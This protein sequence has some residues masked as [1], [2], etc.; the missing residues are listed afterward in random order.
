MPRPWTIPP[1]LALLLCLAL[2]PAAAAGSITLRISARASLQNQRLAVLV[3][4]SNTG[5][6]AAHRLSYTVLLGRRS[7]RASGAARLA[8]GASDQRELTLPFQAPQPGGYGFGVRVD[9]HDQRGYPL[10]AV[11][12]GLFAKQRLA[13][14]RLALSGRAGHPWPGAPPAFVLRNPLDRPLT[15][16]LEV[17]APAEF[18]LERSQWTVQLAPGQ[19]AVVP[20]ELSNRGALTGSTY[21]LAGLASY[22]SGG[23][24]H[25]AAAQVLV[26]VGALSDPLNAWRPWLWAL[27]GL[28][29]AAMLALPWALRRW[30][31]KP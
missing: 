7:A 27:A 13:A 28:L 5:Q 8:P 14:A 26:R 18:K 4:V 29:L 2:A 9:Y 20:V 6:E 21:P 22:L 31:I 11:S 16:R 23:L 17:Y 3:K 1:L 10:S 30:R 12:W 19:E 24:H 25:T 15:V